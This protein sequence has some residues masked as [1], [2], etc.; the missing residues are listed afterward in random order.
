M[1]RLPGQNQLPA[2]GLGQPPLHKVQIQ[3][4]VRSVELVAHDRM[5]EVLQVDADLVFAARERFHAQIGEP[6]FP[7]VI[8]ALAN[9][10]YKA[11]SRRLYEQPFLGDS[12]VLG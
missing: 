9:A 12:Q 7:P 10:L 4:F 11:T 6:P 8:G 5:P 3:P 2:P 1:Q